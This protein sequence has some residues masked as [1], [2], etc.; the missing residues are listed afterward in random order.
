MV[1]GVIFLCLLTGW[2]TLRV[3]LWYFEKS[4]KKTK[5]LNEKT[6]KN[7]AP[8]W[9]YSLIGIFVGLAMIVGVMYLLNIFGVPI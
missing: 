4:E 9:L 5:D 3:L 6:K 8:N 7:E 2:I 1:I